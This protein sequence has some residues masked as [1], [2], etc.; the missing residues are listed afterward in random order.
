MYK[1]QLT[2]SHIENSLTRT[3]ITYSSIDA[4]RS[5]KTDQKS[6]K[7]FMSTNSSKIGAM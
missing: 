1:K 4:I 6:T 3:S 2:G 5:D 7:T